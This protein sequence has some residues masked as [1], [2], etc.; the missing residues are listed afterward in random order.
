MHFCLISEIIHQRKL[1]ILREAELYIILPRVS[2]FDIKHKGY[3]IFVLLHA[4]N[5]KQEAN[6]TQQISVKRQAF[7]GNLN[8]DIFNYKS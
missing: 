5:T 3:G 4:T 1:F 8:Y 7:W 2:N 6:K